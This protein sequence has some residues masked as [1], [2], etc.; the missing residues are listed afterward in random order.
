[1]NSLR[2]KNFFIAI[3]CTFCTNVF[4]QDIHRVAPKETPYSISRMYGLSLEQFYNLNPGRRDNVLDIGEVL[5]VSTKGK[6]PTGKILVNQGQTLYSISKMYRISFLDLKKLNPDLNENLNIGQEIIL[7]LANI[8][9]AEF[10]LIEKHLDTYIPK[11]NEYLVQSK[12]TYYGI[13]KKFNISQEELFRMNPNLQEVGLHPGVYITVKDDND[14]DSS[15]KTSFEY[16]KNNYI[17]VSLPISDE[18]TMYTVK[19]GD[20]VFGILNKFSVGLDYLLLLNPDLSNGLKI[21][22][23]LKLKDGSIIKQS[24]N[25]ALNIT[26]LLPFGFDSGIT[27]YRKIAL[28]FLTGAKLAIERNVAKGRKLNINVIDE[29]G[30][31]SLHAAMSSIDK[32]NTD[33]IVG[34]FFKTG[35]VELISYVSSERIPVVSPFANSEDLQ[36]YNSLVIV[37]TDPKIYA[38]RIAKEVSSAYNGEKIYILG[39]SYA[40]RIQKIIEDNTNNPNIE[41]ISNPESIELE[42]NIMTGDSAPIIAVLASNDDKIKTAFADK[43]V[44]LNK[45]TSGIKAFSMFFSTYFEKI[46][47]DLGKANFVYIVDR[48]INTE[49]EFEKE[50]LSKYYKKY[51]E[52]PS[53]YSIIGFDV[54]NDILERGGDSKGE[55]LRNIDKSLTHLATKFEYKKTENGAYVNN[56]YRVV[57]L[58][59]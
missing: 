57:R 14:N 47:K 49:G 46:E 59:P 44:S 39:S 25:D 58:K 4:A 13:T 48:I 19:Q 33:I 6:V 24:Y 53:K 3:L 27:K 54:I 20:T 2:V 50:I 22:M 36:Q 55:F 41:V 30:D 29:G 31:S 12:D 32:N 21:G 34:P 23:K 45:N 51:C 40:S 52:K 37:E 28:D 9:Y 5:A 15:T 35:L 1:M 10:H 42:K 7:P 38:E 17:S 56:G 43:V 16:E 26:I 18:E 11:Q 8:K